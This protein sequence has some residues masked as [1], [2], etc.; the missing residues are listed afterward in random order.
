MLLK[1]GMRVFGVIEV[2]DEDVCW[3]NDFYVYRL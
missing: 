2:W 3:K 1:Y